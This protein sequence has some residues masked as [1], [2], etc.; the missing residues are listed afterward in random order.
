MFALVSIPVHTIILQDI[1]SWC[2]ENTLGQDSQLWVR[3]RLG[4]AGI[5]ACATCHTESSCNPGEAAAACSAAG[6]QHSWNLPLA[7][8]IW[9][10]FFD[11]WDQYE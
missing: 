3:L 6:S 1:S 9:E 5:P 8:V 7:T 10:M 2:Y 11:F 4:P